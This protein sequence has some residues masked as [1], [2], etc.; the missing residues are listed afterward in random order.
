MVASYVA[1]RADQV[2]Y[3]SYMYMYTL[4]IDS[5]NV[6]SCIH[7]YL[8]KIALLSVKQ[9]TVDLLRISAQL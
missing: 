8:C 9:Y 7:V 5:D 2:L 6:G 1:W 3:G 4:D